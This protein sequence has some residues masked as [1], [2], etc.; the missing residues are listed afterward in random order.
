MFQ[1]R[2]RERPEGTDTA[3]RAAETQDWIWARLDLSTGHF[4]AELKRG[5]LGAQV[6]AAQK[7][8]CALPE[9]GTCPGAQEFNPCNGAQDVLYP[10]E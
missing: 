4:L 7:L 1:R 5:S 8:R 9:P 3:G 10:T 6:L 2:G